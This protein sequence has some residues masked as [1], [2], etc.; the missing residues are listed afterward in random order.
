MQPEKKYL[1]PK[2]G[3]IASFLG[4]V[5]TCFTQ[6]MVVKH[7]HFWALTETQTIGPTITLLEPHLMVLNLAGR[8]EIQVVMVL[9]AGCM[10]NTV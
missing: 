10:Q 5:Q 4:M 2:F 7:G 8:V 3:G 6:L 1:A 9:E